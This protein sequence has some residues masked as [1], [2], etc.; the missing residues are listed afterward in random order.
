MA[1]SETFKTVFLAS[2]PICK[3]YHNLVSRLNSPFSG[4]I[5]LTCG[6][7]DAV[8]SAI[9]FLYGR[10]PKISIDNAAD[11]LEKAEFLMIEELKAYT[12]RKIKSIEVEAENCFKLLFISSRY[13]VKLE[14]VETFF[15]AH[16][17]ELL[18]KEEALHLD[19]DYI[20]YIFTDETL[21]YVG[22][23]DL[24]LF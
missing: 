21:S 8:I 11:I 23:Q 9:Y 2:R 10:R 12:I 19:R 1:Q 14:R 13:D 6:N 4:F 24:F 15:K 16:L 18:S 5:K 22:R 3:K 7:L 20:Y 17:Q